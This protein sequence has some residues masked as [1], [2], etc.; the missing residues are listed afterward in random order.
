MGYANRLIIRDYPDLAEDGDKVYV[1][2][3]NP[4][5]LPLS[6]LQPRDVPVDD[7]G[8]PID[9]EAATSATYALIAGLVHDWHVYDANDMSDNPAPLALPATESSVACLPMEILADLLAEVGKV[10]AV[11]Q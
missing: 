10:A 8:R 3:I 11:P 1:T 4:K 6:K 2:I 5:T 9:P 7:A